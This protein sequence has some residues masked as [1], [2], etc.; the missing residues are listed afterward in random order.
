MTA[1]PPAEQWIIEKMN[2]MEVAEMI[3]QY[4]NYVDKEGN[5]VHL[6]MQ[7][8]RH[9]VTRHDG[10][11]PTIVAVATLPIVLADGNI[12]G[13]VEGFDRLRGIDFRTQREV[14][15]VIPKRENCDEAAVANALRFLTDEWLC[16]VATDYMGK[17]AVI[18]CALT[19]TERSL[20]PSRPCFFITA[21]RRGGGK[22][23]LI[24]MLINGVLGL[25]PAATRA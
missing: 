22:T 14:S 11:L 17:C 4:I 24:E 19:I 8:V 9:Y 16:D 15:A 7:F 10:V 21:G 13:A 3:E 2:E 18:A 25:A 12:I 20:L 5:S 6:P 1:L 23:T